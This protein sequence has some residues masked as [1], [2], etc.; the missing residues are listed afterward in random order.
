MAT[1]IK[2]PAHTQGKKKRN[3][4]QGYGHTHKLP[5]YTEK[6]KYALHPVVHKPRWMPAGLEASTGL[7]IARA[8]PRPV[9]TLSPQL[10]HPLTH[11]FN[12]SESSGKFCGHLP[13][14]LKQCTIH[15][16]YWRHISLLTKAYEGH[17]IWALFPKAAA[18][19]PLWLLCAALARVLSSPQLI[20]SKPKGTSAISLSWKKSLNLC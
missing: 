8:C 16:M 2:G 20:P 5:R 18:L 1:Q 12:V 11:I 9:S 7:L 13:T 14:S 19:S 3:T 6:L 15:I 10:P 4:F 17:W